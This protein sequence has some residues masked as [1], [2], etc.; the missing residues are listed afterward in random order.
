MTK[1]KDE[2]LCCTSRRCFERV[3]DVSGKTY[4][5]VACMSHVK[6]LHKHSDVIAP[7]VVKRFISSS[8]KQK[9][10]GQWEAKR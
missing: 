8:S 7:G 4:D 2:C 3:V 6:D 10:G 9:R 5:E 1:R